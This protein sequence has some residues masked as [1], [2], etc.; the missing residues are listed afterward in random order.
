MFSKLC[1]CGIIFSLHVVVLERNVVEEFD[2]DVEI[3][4]ILVTK[5]RISLCAAGIGLQ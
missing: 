1:T 2:T 3:L 4:H 5:A